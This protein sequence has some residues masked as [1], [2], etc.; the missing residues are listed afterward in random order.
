MKGTAIAIG[1]FLLLTVAVQA[2]AP[3]P[4]PDYKKLDV[5]NGEWTYEVEYKA[6][7]MGA[8]GKA[9]GKMTIQMIL[10]GFAQQVHY[11]EKGMSGTIEGMQIIG[12]NPTIKAFTWNTWDNTG[13]I[14]S[15]SVT[16][17]GNTWNWKG[18]TIQGGKRFAVR[19]T[20]VLSA[21][22]K[23]DKYTLEI[24]SDEKTWIPVLES[25]STKVK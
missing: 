14:I 3:K 17:N 9:T 13:A 4:G 23:T 6:S 5:W 2:Q 22:F 21:D 10:G 8:A 1:I 24:S 7:P 16:V 19:G 25:I 18:T 20:D 11:S 12:Y 15:G